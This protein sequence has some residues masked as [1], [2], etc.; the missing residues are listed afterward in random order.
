MLRFPR[1]IPADIFLFMLNYLKY[2]I[3]RTAF[4]DPQARC[5]V[6][7]DFRRLG[8]PHVGDKAFAYVSEESDYDTVRLLFSRGEAW[9]FSFRQGGGWTQL[10][11]ESRRFEDFWVGNA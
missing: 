4:L 7:E 1:D 10:P 6:D 3:D 11:Q 2:P 8:A 9:E 5:T